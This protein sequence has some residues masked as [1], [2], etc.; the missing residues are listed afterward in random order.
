MSLNLFL[1]VVHLSDG[2]QVHAAVTQGLVSVVYEGICAAES[3]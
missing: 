3:A 2:V 1:A